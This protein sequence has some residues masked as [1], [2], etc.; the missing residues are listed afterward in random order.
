[1]QQGQMENMQRGGPPG[2]EFDTYDE[3]VAMPWVLAWALT[4]LQPISRSWANQLCSIIL[5]YWSHANR[6]GYNY[7][8]FFFFAT[9]S[10]C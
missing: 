10:T 2:L 4:S 9:N 7:K 5:I 8:T 6:Y 3:A 1:M